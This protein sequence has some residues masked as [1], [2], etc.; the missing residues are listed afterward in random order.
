MDLLGLTNFEMRQIGETNIYV[1]PIGLGCWPIAGMTTLGATEA[2][3]RKTILTAIESGINFLDTAHGYGAD[4]LSEKLIGQVIRDRREDL[5]IASKGGLHWDDSG[6]R[7]FDSKPQRIRLECETSLQR[8]Q[9]ETIDLYYLHAHD[10]NTPIAETA[11]EFLKLKKEGKIRAVGVS[12]LT[13]DQIAEFHEVCPVDANQPP[14]NLLQRDIEKHELP[15]CLGKGIATITYWPLMKGL[16][17]GKIRRGHKFDPA[18]GRLNYEI[19][20]GE[21]FEK[22]Q[23]LL[24]QLD[25]LASELGKTV[26]QVV[27][28]W[29]F[30][31][32]GILSV[33]CGA[34]RDWQIRE[35]AGS[36]GWQLTPDQMKTIAEVLAEIEGGVDDYGSGDCT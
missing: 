2:D 23:Q 8:M 36:L 16:L 22:A 34:K 10:P 3:S 25:L 33:L 11:A 7:H 6:Q 1:S 9:I 12:N 24:D 35:A 5:V 14:Y 19:F 18:D 17:A 26:L 13:T 27:V 15:W 29:T 30:H 31:Q 32:S 20:Q 4:G 28:N 21:Q